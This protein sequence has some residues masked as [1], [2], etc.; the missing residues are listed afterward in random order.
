MRD[1]AEAANAIRAMGKPCDSG[2]ALVLHVV[3]VAGPGGPV[4][5][6]K[7]KRLQLSAGE[8][9]LLKGIHTCGSFGYV[10]FILTPLAGGEQDVITRSIRFLGLKPQWIA[11]QL[12]AHGFSR[13]EFFG[14]YGSDEFEE[15]VSPDIIAVAYKE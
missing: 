8:C 12:R 3:Q 1:E 4:T 9:L 11:E 15:N 6:D 7:C 14:G 2:G 10:D 5:W 13:V